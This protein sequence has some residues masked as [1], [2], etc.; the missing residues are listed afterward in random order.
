VAKSIVTNA[1]RSANKIAVAPVLIN[2]PLNLSDFIFMVPSFL[3][4]FRRALNKLNN[5]SD[6]SLG[7]GR[8]V[9]SKDCV[10]MPRTFLPFHL[11]CA[12]H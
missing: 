5:V 10:A 4:M 6:L 12:M 9:L 3:F 2:V 11:P 1:I 7:T 8:S